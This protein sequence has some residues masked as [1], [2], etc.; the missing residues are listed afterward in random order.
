[1]SANTNADP[2]DV[3]QRAAVLGGG[4][5]G[6]GIAQV[7]RLADLDV[8]L[9]DADPDLT[10]P[11]KQR[12]RRRTEIQVEAGL[13]SHEALT[14][15]DEVETTYPPEDA[16]SLVEASRW[17]TSQGGNFRGYRNEDMP[18][19][20]RACDLPDTRMSRFLEKRSARDDKQETPA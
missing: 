2:A 5:M 11:A 16:V 13:I 17:G 8:V 1:M 6:L 4:T 18:R 10:A 3:M 12:L 7:L 14:R 20:L 9:C 15:I 19:R